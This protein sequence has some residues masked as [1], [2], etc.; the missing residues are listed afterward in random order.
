MELFS[1]R[2]QRTFQLV[3]TPSRKVLLE[4]LEIGGVCT[5]GMLAVPQLPQRLGI[6]GRDGGAGFPA[7]LGLGV[8]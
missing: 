6:A 7:L 1:I 2:I 5:D 8:F 3:S 4:L